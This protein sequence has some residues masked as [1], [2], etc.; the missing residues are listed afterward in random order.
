MVK[1]KSNGLTSKKLHHYGAWASIGGVVVGILAVGLTIYLWAYPRSTG[2]GVELPPELV[3]EL[4]QQREVKIQEDLRQIASDEKSK[5]FV[6]EKELADV[7]AKLTYNEKARKNLEEKYTDATKALDNL[8]R[9]FAPDRF[10]QA[11]VALKKG[12][13]GQA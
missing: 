5:R 9:D 1:N 2:K 13:V 8:S 3:K 7:R 6:L 10:K 4:Y 12:D 11:Q